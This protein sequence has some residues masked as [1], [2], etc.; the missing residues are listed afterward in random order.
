[1]NA[2]NAVGWKWTGLFGCLALLAG[3]LLA[4]ILF[5]ATHFGLSAAWASIVHY[6]ETSSEQIIIRTTRLPRAFIALAIGASLAVSG[7]LMQ[8]LTRNPLA[9]PG[10][11]GINAGATCFVVL[12]AV[13]G[14]VA[15][16]QALAWTA[17][18]GAAIAAAT[19]YVLGSLGRGGMSSLKII[20]AGAAMSALFA[21]ITQGVLVMDQKG[22]STVLFWLTGTIAG[23]SADMLVTVLPYMALGLL[24][25]QWIAKDMNVL[26][27][28]DEAAQGLGQRTTAVKLAA[29]LVT[30]VLAGA[31]VSIAGPIGFIGIVVPHVARYLIGLDHRWIIPYSAV[32]GG[33]LLLLADLAARFILIPEE[34][35]VGVMTAVVGAPFFIYVARKGLSRK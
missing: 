17:F 20:L 13:S 7:A 8:A 24:V 15:S 10:V 6:D 16:M 34:M 22:L 3:C 23:R 12:A 21:S 26:A 1:M 19:V 31:S 29:G 30:V 14:S 11:L 35:P 27:M 2:M 18:L 5:G 33:I 9:S 28:G 4:S 32:L 25:A